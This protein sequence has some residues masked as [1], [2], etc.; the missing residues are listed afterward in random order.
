[1]SLENFDIRYSEEID[2]LFLNKWASQDQVICWLPFCDDREMESATNCWIGFSK[3]KASLTAT[4]NNVP[5]GIATLFLMPYKKVA[6]H[7]MF[8]I[9][10]DPD[11]QNQGV[12]SSLIKNIKHLAKNRFKL[13]LLHIEVMDK[14]PI[15]SLL[16]KQGFKQILYQEDYFK[17]GDT[18][19]PRVLLEANL[20]EDV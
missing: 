19:I 2:L 14:N 11:F 17:D 5:C 20:M 18:F 7:S 16:F 9:V 6:H 4:I 8:K 15:L 3:F 13:E 12:G 10:V 1:M